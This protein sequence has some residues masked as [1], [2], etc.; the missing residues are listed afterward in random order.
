MPGADALHAALALARQSGPHTFVDDVEAP[1]LSEPDHRHLERSLRLRE[2]DALTVADGRGRWRSCRFGDSLEL[3]GE[4]VDVPRFEPEVAVGFALVKGGRPETIVQKLTE[5]GA[6]RIV[7]FQAERSVVVWDDAKVHK[8]AARLDRVAREAAMQSHRAWLP[9][10]EPV[11]AFTDLAVRPNV[12]RADLVG[13]P[14]QLGQF[15][16]VGPEGGWSDEERKAVVASSL[17]A[18]HVLRSETAAISAGT[19]LIAARWRYL[20][21]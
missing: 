13:D 11:A 4:V 10:I 7:P 9:V 5:L 17:F 12:V 14:P 2:G 1:V 20:G 15:V 18:P 21:G 8:N 16:L 6:D 3:I 19:L